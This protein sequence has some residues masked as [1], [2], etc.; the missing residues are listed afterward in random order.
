M[1]EHMTLE[2]LQMEILNA[3][4]INK[5]SLLTDERCSAQEEQAAQ[6]TGASEESV[7]QKVL[8]CELMVHPGY[9]CL[10]VESGGCGTGADDFA[11]SS[12]R[13]HELKLLCCG[14][15]KQFYT[16]FNINLVSSCDKGLVSDG[17]SCT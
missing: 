17:F 16:N 13:K 15:M 2:T 7:N 5:T 6:S 1:G 4:N 11:I 9:P 8:T 14:E 10:S 12:D 3:F